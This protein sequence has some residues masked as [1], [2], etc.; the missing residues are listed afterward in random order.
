[1]SLRIVWVADPTWV[2]LRS[3]TYEMLSGTKVG[4]ALKI[5]HEKR[6]GMRVGGASKLHL[7]EAGRAI[8]MVVPKRRRG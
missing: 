8:L 4:E 5:N 6:N 1:M 2:E 3:S 7:Q